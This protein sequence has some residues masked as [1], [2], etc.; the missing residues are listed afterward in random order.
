MLD[1]ECKKKYDNKFFFDL[2]F[3]DKIK[4][5]NYSIFVIEIDKNV[6]EKDVINMFIRLNFIEYNLNV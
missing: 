2:N 1:E 5:W 6:N 4:I 3:E